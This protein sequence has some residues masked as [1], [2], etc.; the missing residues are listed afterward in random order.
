[1][2]TPAFP[3]LS[4]L[5]IIA[6]ASFAFGMFYNW[7]VDHAHNLGIFEPLVSFSVAGGVASTVIL[8]GALLWTFPLTGWQWVL[9][10]LIAFAA[11]GVPMIVGSLNREV[12]KVSHHRQV[13]T[14]AA[15]RARD[16]VI[17]DLTLLA[18]KL[19]SAD[20]VRSLYQIIG[21]LKAI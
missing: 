15:A 19:D 4:T 1:M 11:S 7:L 17:M 5:A 6:L 16:E 12:R 2:Q 9:V 3:P 13:I 21:T 8:A 10:M 20:H 14:G 18:A